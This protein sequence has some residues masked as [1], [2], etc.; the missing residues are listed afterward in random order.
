MQTTTGRPRLTPLRAAS[1]GLRF[2]LE[3]AGLAAV[4]YWGVVVGDG[5]LQQVALAV[6]AV[7]FFVGVWGLFVAPKAVRRLGDPGRLVVELIVFGVVVVAL[8]SVGQ[9]LVGFGFGLL[10]VV[11]E[12]LVVVLGQRDEL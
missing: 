7:V 6:G 1:A 2:L 12:V 9:I 8:V 4:A 11:S 3:L 5:L 10:V